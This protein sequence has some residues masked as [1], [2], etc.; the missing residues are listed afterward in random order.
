MIEDIERYK[1]MLELP[2]Q[3]KDNM[4]LALT[5]L[6][7]KI[8]STEVLKSTKI[9]H[10]VNRTRKKHADPEVRL[11][12]AEVYTQWR[13]FVEENANK[14]SIEVRSDK[15]SEALR[16]N[17]RRLLAEALEVKVDCRLVDNIEREVF[18]QSSR[19]VSGSY[20]RTVRALVFAFRHKP[21]VR[22]Q[23]KDGQT[24]VGHLVSNHK[25]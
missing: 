23:V 24:S 7:K 13:T 9:G 18:H 6:N 15:R 10:T 2:E 3:T 17:A 19:L 21:N 25:K 8:P 4:L 11:L 5:E 1:A 20:R 16:S 22:L 14:L 12:A